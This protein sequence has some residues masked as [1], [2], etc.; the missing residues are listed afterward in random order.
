MLRVRWKCRNGCLMGRLQRVAVQ[1][2]P[3]RAAQRLVA[4]CHARDEESVSMT[5]FLDGQLATGDQV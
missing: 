3:F 1:G 4:V 2:Q 5:N